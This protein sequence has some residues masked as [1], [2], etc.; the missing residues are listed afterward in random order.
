MN[1][2]EKKIENKCTVCGF[3]GIVGRP[4]VG[5]STLQNT[6]IGKKVSITAAKPQTT[7][8]QILG[9]KTLNETQYIYVD[10]PGFH[11]HTGK[12]L[13]KHLNRVVLQALEG[14][15]VVLF[16]ID[17]R[18]WTAEDDM[19]LDRLTTS[20]VPIILVINKIDLLPHREK[21]FS[22][23]EKLKQRRDFAAFVPVSA[24]KEKHIDLLETE[25]KKYLPQAPH[26]FSS[27]ALSDKT[28]IFFSAEVIREKLT[29]LLTAELP[30][31]ISVKIEKYEEK[32]KLLHIAAV[33]YVEREGQKAIVIGQKGENLKKI[34]KLA[35]TELERRLGKKIF[36]ELWV[37]IKKN[38]SDDK[39][40]LEMMGYNI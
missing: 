5:K 8:D 23:I 19:L 20:T 34:G 40:G 6:L 18:Y 11:R 14:L 15:D 33:I 1:Q 37:K 3:V 2:Q 24:L 25:I 9:V 21:L 10:T 38:W 26:A 16:V 29:R 35:R 32:E 36:L 7:R 31:A 39:K 12:A 30:Y 27:D 4:N 22:L 28:P 13:N 17:V